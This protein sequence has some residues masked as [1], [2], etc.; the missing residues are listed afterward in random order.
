MDGLTAEKFHLE[1]TLIAQRV[2]IVPGS[3][4]GGAALR[5]ELYGHSID[6]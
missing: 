4:I 5:V 1:P 3:W 6:C 2:R